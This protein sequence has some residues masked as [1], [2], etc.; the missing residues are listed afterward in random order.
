MHEKAI[1]QHHNELETICVQHYW[2]VPKDRLLTDDRGRGY[3][4]RAHTIVHVGGRKTRAKLARSDQ[5]SRAASSINCKSRVASHPDQTNGIEKRIEDE[6]K[7][8]LLLHASYDV[9]REQQRTNE[10]TPKLEFL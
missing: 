4:N 2:G 3:P 7:G 8:R 9:P 10:R 1:R 5:L 6:L